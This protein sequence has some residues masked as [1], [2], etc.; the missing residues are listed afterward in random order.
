MDV[1]RE[2]VYQLVFS[3]GAILLFVAGAMFVSTFYGST[4]TDSGIT[5]GPTGG[6]ALV[7]VVAAF[8]IL[9]ALAGSWLETQEFDS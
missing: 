9:M 6:I 7:A 4:S 8:V 3:A 5:I 1:D 2:L